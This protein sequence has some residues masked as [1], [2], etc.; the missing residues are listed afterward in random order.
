[1]HLVV[2]FITVPV[3]LLC[4]LLGLSAILEPVDGIANMRLGMAAKSVPTTTAEMA[5]RSRENALAV[6][7]EFKRR[8][9]PQPVAV[10]ATG[11]MPSNVKASEK[12]SALHHSAKTRSVRVVR[13][14][15]RGEQAA[16]NSGFALVPDAVVSFR[17]VND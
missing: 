1:M 12:I 6:E 2:Y 17:S 11:A 13:R 4:G 14:D 16:T 15:T 7:A 9:P 5:A 10:A 8:N 3:L